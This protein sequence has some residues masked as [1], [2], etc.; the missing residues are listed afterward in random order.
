M[1]FEIHVGRE[2]DELLLETA[3]GVTR[4]MIGSERG[5]EGHSA[6]A[7]AHRGKIEQYT[8]D[9]PKVLLDLG[10]V[11]EAGRKREEA[12]QPEFDLSFAA[13]PSETT[14]TH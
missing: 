13:S 6:S 11:L 2:D 3:G 7:R 1:N 4:E 5:R 14:R 12:S 8:T 9:L 10:V